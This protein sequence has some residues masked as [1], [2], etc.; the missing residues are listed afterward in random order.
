MYIL[1]FKKKEE[2]IQGGNIIP[3]RVFI[4]EIQCIGLMKVSVP[5][6]IKVKKLGCISVV[7][8]HNFFCFSRKELFIVN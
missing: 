5:N 2:P 3:S 8:F 4:K 1:S 6:N 7:D